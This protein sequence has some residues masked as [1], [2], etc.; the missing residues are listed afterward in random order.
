MG[1]L[2]FIPI[3]FIFC[4]ASPW[5]IFDFYWGNSLTHMLVTAFGLSIFGPKVTQGLGLYSISHW[6]PT[7]LSSQWHN[8]LGNSP[9]IATNTLPRL[10]PKFSKM[11]KYP[12][13]CIIPH[14]MHNLVFR[15]L[16][17]AEK[18]N[19]WVKVLSSTL[20]SNGTHI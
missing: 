19:Q 18:S 7:G 6:V 4:F 10:V 5:L 9:K 17:F 16:A 20:V 12:Q 15:T 1:Y 3:F 2:L 13:Y 8:Q 14:W 11:W